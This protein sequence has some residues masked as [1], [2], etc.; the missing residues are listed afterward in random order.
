MLTVKHVHTDGVE[1]LFE[2]SEIKV[3]R[4]R[5]RFED[6]IFLDPIETN[7]TPP[8]VVNAAASAQISPAQLGFKHCIH[9][10]EERS[11]DDVQPM[12]YVMNR[13]GATVASYRL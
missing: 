12:V 11:S 3:V 1:R 8:G 7:D 13:F 6:G 9:F 10:A 5:N 2:A 4:G